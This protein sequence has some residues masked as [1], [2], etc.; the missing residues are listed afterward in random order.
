MKKIKWWYLLLTAFFYYPILLNQ[1]IVTYAV[2]YLVPLAFFILHYQWTLE[3]IHRIMMSKLR[4]AVWAWGIVT[5]ASI[6]V[7][8]L[9]KTNDFSY[10]TNAPIDI[11]K[12]SYRSL[13]LLG[14]YEI[15]V[16]KEKDVKMFMRYFIYSCCL[17][18]LGTVIFLI[19]PQV[20]EFWIGIISIPELDMTHIRKS[21]YATRFGWSG[22]S[23]FSCTL[24]CCMCVIFTIYLIMDSY[25]KKQNIY[26]EIIALVWLLVGNMFYGRT[27][28]VL[29]IICICIMLVYFLRRKPAY[30]VWVIMLAS[31]GIISLLILKEQSDKVRNWYNWCFSVINN[32]VSSG[33]IGTDSTDILFGR[34]L[35]IPKIETIILGDGKFTRPDGLYYMQTDSGIMRPM[36]FYGV[37]FMLIGFYI[38]WNLIINLRKSNQKKRNIKLQIMMF[39]LFL[40]W[41]LF[42]IKGPTFYLMATY[43][44]PI[45]ILFDE[46]NSKEEK[47]DE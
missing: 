47:K 13:F 31:I 39:N 15:Y 16:D 42:E 21:Y 44:L 34:M 5:S 12:F 14:V 3:S 19:F 40:V 1:K 23:G 4:Y 41:A 45:T 46:E 29:S 36:L 2:V 37:F 6:I 9:M 17:Y 33:R 8:I 11:V 28:L 22:F 26:K 7:P 38:L 25:E 32:F 35:F 10:F 18:I 30:I 24:W 43:L 20:K 27:G